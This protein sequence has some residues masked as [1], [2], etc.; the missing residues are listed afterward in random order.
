[1]PLTDYVPDFRSPI[2][3]GRIASTLML[4][5]FYLLAAGIGL[6][7]QV[8]YGAVTPL[9]PPSGLAVWMLWRR[10]LGLAPV[11]LG[12]EWLVA[13]WLGQGWQAQILGPLAQLVE[14]MLASMLLRLARLPA[15]PLDT[16]HGLQLFLLD[17]VL[18]APMLAAAIGTWGLYLTGATGDGPL[19]ETLL[20]WWTGDALGIL[21]ITPL[22]LAWWPQP[23]RSTVAQAAAL[24]IAT[25]IAALVVLM[26][27]PEQRTMLFFLLLPFVAIAGL[28][29][30]PAVVTL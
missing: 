17:A 29:R 11:I 27:A 30:D 24:M 6:R 4:L 23:A 26:Q 14:A 2:P 1:M 21:I 7:L 8:Y 16:L 10:G 9:W 19:Y 18:L 5:A 3:R 28:L 15:R 20:T 22:L 12:G 25:G 13:L